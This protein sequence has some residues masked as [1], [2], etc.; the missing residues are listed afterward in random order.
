RQG[1]FDPL[2][3]PL[4]QETGDDRQA[5]TELD[6]QELLPLERGQALLPD[7]ATLRRLTT[8]FQQTGLEV[9]GD[10]VELP[11]ASFAEDDPGRLQ[12]S[13][14]ERLFLGGPL[15]PRE[16]DG[17]ERDCLHVALGKGAGEERRTVD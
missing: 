13:A 1:F 8:G 7:Q 10:V 3:H 15:D 11:A 4:V 14:R 16:T 17:D 5:M 6:G 9:L 12:E 2:G